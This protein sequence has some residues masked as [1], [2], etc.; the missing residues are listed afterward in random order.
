M[1]QWIQSGEDEKRK[2]QDEERER[3]LKLRENQ[4]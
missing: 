3:T 4:K 2:L 1:K